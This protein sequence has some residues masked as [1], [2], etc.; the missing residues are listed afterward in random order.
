M[1]NC[2]DMIVNPYEIFLEPI[3]MNCSLIPKGQ[4]TLMKVKA[5]EK[6]SMR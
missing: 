6:Y 3:K 1:I 5:F 4:S 2:N